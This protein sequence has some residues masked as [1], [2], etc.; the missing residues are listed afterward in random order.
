MMVMC[1]SNS[2]KEFLRLA[3]EMPEK[4]GMLVGP[5][6]W[7]VPQC[8]YALDNDAYIAWNKQKAW[9]EAAW[10]GML[11]KAKNV[12]VGPLW[13]LVPDVVADPEKTLAKWHQYKD[14]VRAFGWLLAFAVQDGMG[15]SDVPVD[16]SVVFIGGTTQWKWRTLPMWAGS[17]PRVHLGR[18][19]TSRGKLERLEALGIESCDGSGWFRDTAYGRNARHLKAYLAHDKHAQKEF[20]GFM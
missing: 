15:I 11:E 8:R 18:C 19:G 16:A 10:L 7:R 2:N 12:A 3:T 5:S 6:T 14:R 4:V 20:C 9:S 13:A 17:F 1:A